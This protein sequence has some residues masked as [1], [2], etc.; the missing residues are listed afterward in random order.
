MQ[1]CYHPQARFSDPVFLKLKDQEAGWMWEMLLK[2]SQDLKVTY[3]NVQ[4]NDRRGSCDWEAFY[5]FT[6][7]G[8]PVHN[9]IQANFVFKDEL[10][11]R[12]DD[13][14]SFYDWAS[15]ALGWTG[16]L[17]GWSRFVEQKVQSKAKRGLQKFIEGKKQK[18]Q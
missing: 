3:D 18:A 1:Q 16:R 13:T 4:A 12:H 10:I 14:F 9:R 2:S 11:F 7:T 15:Q 6:S 8:R 17:L 5:T